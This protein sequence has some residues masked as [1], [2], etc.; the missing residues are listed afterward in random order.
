M[1]KVIYLVPSNTAVAMVSR[2][3]TAQQP[4]GANP[5]TCS[6][7]DAT[8]KSD[9][10]PPAYDLPS[11][12]PAVTVTARQ[13][14]STGRF[15]LRRQKAPAGRSETGEV[16][17]SVPE[18]DRAAEAGEEPS[19]QFPSEPPLGEREMEAAA[20]RDVDNAVFV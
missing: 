17:V 13:G 16:S 12:D 9:T 2:A 11:H 8:A 19:Q 3:D 10:A 1:R 14:L 6:A 18:T 20:S 7:T 4:T 15:A 5:D